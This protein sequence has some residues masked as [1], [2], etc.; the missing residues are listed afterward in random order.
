MLAKAQKLEQ[1]KK[2]QGL[3]KSEQDKLDKYNAELKALRE[4]GTIDNIS[5]YMKTWEKWYALQQK[6]EKNGKLSDKDAKT[7]DTYKAQLDAWNKEKQTQIDDLTS[8]MKDEL[9]ALKKTYAENISEAES[10]INSYYSNLYDLARQIA[11]YNLI[12][13]FF[14]INS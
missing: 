3:S 8:L 12:N 13:E 14:G 1:K 7:Y 6:L 9:E 4:G 2:I 11:E 10:E 5:E